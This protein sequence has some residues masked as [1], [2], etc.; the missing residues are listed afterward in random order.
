MDL[1]KRALLCVAVLLVP[2]LARAQL[3]SPGELAKAHA[4]WDGLGNCGKC[5]PAGK[6]LSADACLACHTE[7]KRRVDAGTGFHGRMNATERGTCNR[8][9]RDHEGR[10]FSLIVWKPSKEHFDH[11]KSGWP[12]RGAHEGK[13]CALCHEPRRLVDS[14]AQAL[15]KRGAETYL[16][17]GKACV[18]CH[19][20]E[21]R[22]QEKG[23]CDR[24]HSETAWKPVPRFEH[25]NTKFPLL[26]KHA[27]VACAG[28]H[29]TSSDE[30]SRGSFPPSRATTFLRMAPVDHERCVT[31]H[32]DP[33]GGRFGSGCESC[34][35][36][37]G[38]ATIVRKTDER[39]FHD[40]TRFP[41]KGLHSGVPCAACHGP[42]KG[43]PAKFKG[44]AFS[45]CRDCHA[46]AHSG[47]L[48]EAA[49]EGCH[50]VAGWR[51]SL[52]ELEDHN[53]TAY[54]LTGAHAAV[55]CTSCHT[56]RGKATSKLAAIQ[57]RLPG[58]GERCERCHA[59]VHVGQLKDTKDGC[60]HCHDTASFHKLRFAHS[61]SRFPLT[62]AHEKTPC[63]ACHRR[64]NLSGT[65][66]T[67]YKPIDTACIS[68][69]ADVHLG[70]F[71]PAACERCHTSSQFTKT[72]F[73]HND[74][75]YTSYALQGR[76]GRL[77]C[78]SC[79][80]PVTID[81]AR[82][83][84]R[85]KPL[86][87][88]CESCHADFHRGDFRGLA[89]SVATVSVPQTIVK[90]TSAQTRCELCHRV[91][92]W[93][94]VRFPHEQTGFPLVDAHRKVAC[95]SCHPTSF[96]A[97]VATQ[98]AGCH[99]DAHAGEFGQRC[100]GCH[101][102]VSWRTQFSAD[103]H[104]AT[105]FPL[106]GRHALIP[107]TECHPNARDRSFARAAVACVSCHRA[108]YD[109]AAMTSIDHVRSGFTTEC[110]ACHNSFRWRPARYPAHDKCFRVSTGPHAGIRC[111]GCHVALP[112]PE[113][114]GACASNNAACT[115]CHSHSKSKTDAQH[116]RLQVQGYDYKDQKCYACHTGA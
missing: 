100:E 19:F 112:P 5:H 3:A 54:A 92:G 91:Q 1:L 35:T 78:A 18:S 75:R 53:K 80:K 39:A 74:L 57:L 34:H 43:K 45:K 81:G 22:G 28:C 102:V 8:C 21:H 41:L 49:C 62:G 95:K 103:A 40:R 98:C 71:Q 63:V 2:A 84:A 65:E 83:V 73:D 44:L 99:R 23:A 72:K 96:R 97:R 66:V 88:A 6:Q 105:N 12:L 48:K 20:D 16:G 33:H 25:G 50:N 107:C 27:G 51:P 32:A 15:M 11:G 24:C 36:V 38:W 85:Y 108:D 14:D 79:H 82:T 31:C 113:T 26:G 64:E 29:P 77:A 86:P 116:A 76:H 94:D 68:C 106:S 56:N 101:D 93:D 4:K 30:K 114:L 9:H 37:D 70:Q 42:S 13:K 89:P 17:V 52:F 67:R 69:H 115:S 111:L 87:R 47:Q 7:L 55:A 104:R 46:D 109:R 90:S 10:D 58:R 60:A 61:E 110:R 59:D